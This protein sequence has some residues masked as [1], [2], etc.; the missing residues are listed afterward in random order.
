MREAIDKALTMSTNEK[1][2]LYVMKR[3]GYVVDMNPYHKYATIRSVNSK[4]STRLYRLGEGYDRDGIYERMRENRQNNSAETYRLY[5]EFTNKKSFGINFY[6]A[7]SVKGSLKSA[8]KITGFKAL[9]FRYLYLLG[10]LPKNRKHTPLSPEMREAC[11]KL[12]SY[13]EQ[14]RLICKQKL[15]DIPSVES[16]IQK[17]DTEIKLL[18]DY[19]KIL[20]RDIDSC[21]NTEEREVLVDKRNDCTK[22]LALLRK[23]KKTALRLIEDNPEI[24]EKIRIEEQMRRELIAPQK[25]KK[26]GYER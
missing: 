2:F 14:V 23:D 15:T 10:V 16:F 1:A 5:Y 11:R 19:R 4:K 13:S 25:Y 9:Y 3:L 21:H 20:Y 17:T 26:R 8:S 12:D 6:K 7:H 24:K 18:T 22:S